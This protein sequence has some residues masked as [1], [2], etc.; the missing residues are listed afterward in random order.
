MSLM[1]VIQT[2]I[3][4]A[5]SAMEYSHSGKILKECKFIQQILLGYYSK[6]QAPDLRHKLIFFWAM[7]LKHQWEGE[8]WLPKEMMY[9]VK[10]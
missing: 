2:A 9:F 6:E 7:F 3:L 8:V 5:S 4:A 1:V 10:S